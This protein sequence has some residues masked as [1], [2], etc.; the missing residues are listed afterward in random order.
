MLQCCKKA[1]KEQCLLQRMVVMRR[2]TNISQSE[3]DDAFEWRLKGSERRAAQHRN[4]SWFFL[5]FALCPTLAH[6]RCSLRSSNLSGKHNG[7]TEVSRSAHSL[8]KSMTEKG[9]GQ[10]AQH[11]NGYSN[12]NQVQSC[13]S[14]AEMQ[15][16]QA[17]R[18]SGS[19]PSPVRSIS[20]CR[21]CKIGSDAKRLPKCVTVID[22]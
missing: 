19:I 20:S 1:V 11:N 6:G 12:A 10:Q 4:G 7:R 21:S 14:S 2:V 8:C 13:T 15:Q 5:P 9:D 3:I 18:L 16:C 17:P 22:S